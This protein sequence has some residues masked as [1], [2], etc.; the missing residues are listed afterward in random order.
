[1]FMDYVIQNHVQNDSFSPCNIHR[2]DKTI[3]LMQHRLNPL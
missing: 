3:S 1:M 2:V